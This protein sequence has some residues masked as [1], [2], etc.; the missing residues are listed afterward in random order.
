MKIFVNGKEVTAKEGETLQTLLK[1]FSI[2]D[3]DSGAA[4]AVNE[5]VIPKTNWNTYILKNE[6]R[7][8]IVRA[9]QG[10]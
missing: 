2:M 7:I 10:G 3:D 8:E 5:E 9:V 4:V 1:S 6:N